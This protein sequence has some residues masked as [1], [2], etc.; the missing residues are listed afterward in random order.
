M[1][2]WDEVPDDI[3][4]YVAVEQPDSDREEPATPV[5]ESRVDG[6][7]GCL[8]LGGVFLE[9]SLAESSALSA[10][11]PSI[12][13]GAPEPTQAELET[14]RWMMQKATMNQDMFLLGPPGPRVRHLVHHFC[15]L[16]GRQVEYVGINSD[17]SEADLKQRRDICDG[18]QLGD[19]ANAMGSFN[20]GP[21]THLAA[22]LIPDVEEARLCRRE[23]A[24]MSWTF[25]INHA[26]VT[27]PIL[28]AS[29]VLTN[30]AG[31]AGNAMLYGATLVCSLF[32]SALVFSLIGAKKGLS[33]SMGLYAVYVGLF[34]TAASMCAEKDAKTGSCIEGM[35]LQLPTM[36]LGALIGGIGAGILWTC[37][38]AFFSSVCERV[39]KAEG[40]EAQAVTAEFAGS[41]ALVFLAMESLVRA[42]ATILTKYA[43]LDYSVVFYIFSGLA[44]ASTVAF[45]ALATNFE[46]PAQRGSVFAKVL[47]AV[48]LWSDPKIWVLQ[49]TNLTFGF[50]AAWLGGYVGRNILTP[51]LSSE[52]IGFAGAMLSGLASV[53]SKV[54]GVTAAKTGKGPVVALGA[55]SFLLLGV[56]SRYLGHPA[57]WGWGV[58]VF[59]VFMGIG[60][61][62]YESTNKAIFADFFPGEASPGAFANVFVFGTG[63]S[64][65]AFILGATQQDQAEDWLLI[66]FA[67]LTIPGYLVASLISR[68]EDGETTDSSSC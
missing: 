61:A 37:Q 45:M 60:R 44:V 1:F 27:T 63:A 64:T 14:L 29:S 16:F 18:R 47:S 56:L 53:L 24:V 25:A 15:A 28:Y 54:F 55:V 36:L 8:E 41:F 17:T 3:A 66:L 46:K 26:T 67:I 31:Q 33:L 68:K 20:V 42:S 32:F 40:K 35:D 43:H 23:F 19:R 11:V 10:L 38:G 4:D 57:T 2:D 48:A 52:F 39:A 62:V 12:S 7:P 50:A 34:A 6:G 49:C 5:R 9:K 30:S 65:A 21:E 58:L 51:A 22:A 59:Y 13:E